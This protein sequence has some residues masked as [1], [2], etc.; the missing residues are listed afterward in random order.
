MSRRRKSQVIILDD[1]SL[2]NFTHEEATALLKILEDRY[3]KGS[4]IITS[5]VDPEGWRG[6][7]QDSVI[8]YAIIDR[9]INPSDS[10]F[11]SGESYRKRRKAN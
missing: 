6:L 3:G 9:L 10:T 5:Q 8:S 11:L 4:T 2:R 1:F 7:F